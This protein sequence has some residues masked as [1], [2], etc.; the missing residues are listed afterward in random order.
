[1][2]VQCAQ[3]NEDVDGDEIKYYLDEKYFIKD[4]N[5]IYPFCSCACGT[6]YYEENGYNK[7]DIIKG[8]KA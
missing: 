2:I 4:S 5:A 8:V 3:C 7:M 6:K 1:M